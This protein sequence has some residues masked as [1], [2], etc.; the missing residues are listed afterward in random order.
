MIE[1][2]VEWFKKV[3]CGA[4][5]SIA[6]IVRIHVWVILALAVSSIVITD[7]DVD[8]STTR[9]NLIIDSEDTRDVGLDR[10]DPRGF[11]SNETSKDNFDIAWIGGSTLQNIDTDYYRFLPD[12]AGDVIG[13]VN[14][15]PVD[16]D[17]FFL[18]AM[19]TFD[20]Y[21]ALL[22]AIDTKP[23]LIVLT[24][25]P[26]WILNDGAI[27]SWDN[28]D[29]RTAA[30]I[31]SRPE[32]WKVGLQLLSPTDAAWGL[33]GSRIP[34]IEQRWSFAPSARDLVDDWDL[35]DRS[36]PPEAT[37]Q[38]SELAH[39]RSLRAPLNFWGEYRYPR[40]GA[41]VV[42]DLAWF[43]QSVTTGGIV[44][45]TILSMMAAAIR[46]S[47]IPTYIYVAPISPD[48]LA[49][50]EIEEALFDV[51]RGLDRHFEEFAGPMV[52]F[53]PT[54]LSRVI[55]PLPFNNLVHTANADPLGEFLAGELCAF[56]NGLDSGYECQSAE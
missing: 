27:Q 25:N 2:F 43:K 22:A 31:A 40:P 52:S 49:Y 6:S 7:R 13:S 46:D 41:N 12:I 16:V 45:D 42:P 20:E 14:G 23:D 28:L 21:V 44:N 37:A 4:T 10:N 50:P 32:A 33:A 54:S 8:S 18:S 26:L 17:I 19:R 15:K 48:S 34:A 47:G 35:L 55:D 11:L 1:D 38:Q 3:S 5:D 39:I 24:I 51:E 30:L 29:G 53:N 9:W 56:L 36:V